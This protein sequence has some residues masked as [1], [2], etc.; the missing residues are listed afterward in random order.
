MVLSAHINDILRIREAQEENHRKLL[1]SA[2]AL[3]AELESPYDV[4]LGI[5]KAV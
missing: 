3:V 1:L 2:R 4:M 5:S